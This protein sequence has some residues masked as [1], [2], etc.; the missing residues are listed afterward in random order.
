MKHPREKISDSP[1]THRKK[2]Y[3]HEIPTR[4]I[5][6]PTKYQRRHDREQNGTRLTKLTIDPR[7]LAHSKMSEQAIN[8]AETKSM[9][10]L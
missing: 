7:N 3:T 10:S 9:S 5:F 8:F 4:K 1:N 2:I 6:G